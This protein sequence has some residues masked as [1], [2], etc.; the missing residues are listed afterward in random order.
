MLQRPSDQTPLTNADGVARARALAPMIAAA[1]TRIEAE[2]SI[3]TEI[4]DAMH[5][6]RLFRLLIPRSCGGDELA[7]D[8]FVQVM[9][10]I[11]KAD[12]ST[13]WCVAQACGGSVAAGFLAPHVAREIFGA[14]DAVVASGPPNARA[15]AVAVD[16]GFRVTGTWPF[17]SGI[18]HAT[19]LAAHCPVYERDGSP[20]LGADGKPVER[21]L[22]FVKSSAAINNAWDVIGLRGTGSHTYAVRDLFVPA[23]HSFVR[24]FGLKRPEPGPL[25]RFT[26]MNIFGF[27]FAG[28]ALGIARAT[29]D[30][31]VRLAAD[32][33]PHGATRVLRDDPV[34]QHEVAVAEA[35]LQ[36]ARAYL[37]AILRDAWEVAGAGGF[38]VEQC[39]LMRMGSTYV[40][41]Q[42]REVVDT[43]YRLAGATAI[44]ADRDFERRFR[45][46]H[47]VSQQIQAQESFF[48]AAGQY[49]LGL[50]AREAP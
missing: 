50:H 14:P 1:A 39:A 48:Q 49:L 5:G 15:R 31:F 11:A 17:A 25:Y 19:W 44:F 28:V 27:A 7:L 10:E 4:I 45:D 34:V 42:A 36:A 13:A 12:A 41:R 46:M 47:T 24:E 30:A 26:M 37:L 8:L 3:P 2:G 9:E 35:R 38:T 18:G 40:I 6:A 20:R 22:L 33:R 21:T 43:A 32:K 16:N 23:D 29:L